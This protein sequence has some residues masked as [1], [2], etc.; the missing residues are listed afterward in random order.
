MQE[1]QNEPRP[2]TDH[3]P[4]NALGRLLADAQLVATWEQRSS[5][6]AIDPDPETRARGDD[7]EDVGRD[8]KRERDLH[9]GMLLSHRLARIERTTPRVG[10][11]IR[12]L[13]ERGGAARITNTATRV[14]TVGTGLYELVGKSFVQPDVL[15][16]WRS[17]GD[18]RMPAAHHGRELLDCAAAAWVA[19]P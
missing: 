14:G 2:V 17:A 8:R 10:A 13:V 1:A 4:R 12:W 18:V 6:R 19:C 3:T 5:V 9:A 11:V 16:R 15:A 7:R